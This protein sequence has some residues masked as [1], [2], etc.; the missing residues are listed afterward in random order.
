MRLALPSQLRWFH[1][2]LIAMAVMAPILL[3]G[4]RT[5]DSWQLDIVWARQFTEQLATNPYPRWLERSFD[6]FGAPVF[7][8]YPPGAFYLTAGVHYAA[9]GLLSTFQSIVIAAT[10]AL[11]SSGLTMRAWLK[12]IGGREWMAA[13]F[14]LA[15]YHLFDISIRG[16]LAEFCAYALMPLVMLALKRALDGKSPLPLAASYAALVMTHLPTALLISVLLIAPYAL[17]RRGALVR[18]GLGVALGLALAAIYLAP[19]LLLPMNTAQMYRPY[20]RVADLY[21]WNWHGS[22]LSVLAPQIM[23]MLL[24]L[25][26][27]R[28]RGFWSV[29]TYILCAIAVGL[30]PILMLPILNKVQFPW[31]TLMLIEFCTL[32]KLALDAKTLSRPVALVYPIMLLAIVF[33][34]PVREPLDR[35]PEATEYL[36]PAAIRPDTQPIGLPPPEY[37]KRPERTVADGQVTWRRFNFPAWTRCAAGEGVLVTAPEGCTPEIGLTPPERIGGAISLAGLAAFLTVMLVGLARRRPAE[38]RME[39]A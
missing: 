16:A 37:I 10:L 30:I 25:I 26:L 3:W 21:F 24:A 22:L 31:R 34:P 6:G 19:A 9:G 23:M 27:A 1:L 13:L 15:P 14:M 8:F 11:F 33:H 7:Y 20:F 32:T 38:P 36:P 12:E 17:Y 4:E 28:G 2:A 29:W 39:L 18:A 5:Q 35:F